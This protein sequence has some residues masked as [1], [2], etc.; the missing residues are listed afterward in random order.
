MYT[1]LLENLSS[2]YDGN[3][4][5]NHLKSTQFSELVFDINP[6]ALVTNYTTGSILTF[7]ERERYF[8]TI[9]TSYTNA[10]TLYFDYIV[11]PNLMSSGFIDLINENALKLNG[12]TLY[13]TGQTIVSPVT[14]IPVQETANTLFIEKDIIIDSVEPVFYVDNF[15]YKKEVIN[16]Q[17]A[18]NP[19]TIVN[20]VTGSQSNIILDQETD[21]PL[22]N[23]HK[24]EF[25][26]NEL[27]ASGKT[28]Y[29]II[30]KDSTILPI[31]GFKFSETES[32]GLNHEGMLVVNLTE[33]NNV[34]KVIAKL[35]EFI[36]TYYNDL[37][38]S[39]N[40]ENPTITI[41]FDGN[42]SQIETSPD[43]IN[44]ISYDESTITPETVTLYNKLEYAKDGD[45]IFIKVTCSKEI[46][47]TK[48]LTVTVNN[49]TAYV[50]EDQKTRNSFYASYTIKSS[51][52]GNLLEVS[53]LGSDLAGNTGS[54]QS[55]ENAIT[56]LT[57]ITTP[58]P[59]PSKPIYVDDNIPN[60]MCF[61]YT[62]DPNAAYYE[63]IFYKDG[64]L[65]E[66]F[67]TPMRSYNTGFISSSYY[68]EGTYTCK[69]RAV[70]NV[71]LI[72]D[73][74]PISDGH[75]FEIEK[76]ECS[77]EL[78]EQTN[79]QF[80][81]LITGATSSDVID[82][83]IKYKKP[84]SLDIE[85]VTDI[86]LDKIYTENLAVGTP[87]IL[88]NNSIHI[89]LITIADG[90]GVLK[91]DEGFAISYENNEKTSASNTIELKIDK[92][93]PIININTPLNV[94]SLKHIPIE[95]V[96]DEPISKP[97]I[98]NF[99]IEDGS[100]GTTVE[101]ISDGDIKFNVILKVSE[102][103]S[104]CEIKVKLKAGS[105]QDSAGNTNDVS[106]EVIIIHNSILPEITAVNSK[107][108][109]FNINDSIYVDVTFSQRAVKV[110]QTKPFIVG[111]VNTGTETAPIIFN[112]FSGSGTTNLRFRHVVSSNDLDGNV[113]LLTL[114]PGS[115]IIDILN[116]VVNTNISSFTIQGVFIVKSS[117]V[118]EYS[119]IG[120][121]K[122][123]AE[124]LY[125][126]NSI[127][128]NVCVSGI[129]DKDDLLL[130]IFV[131]GSENYMVE[132]EPGWFYLKDKEYYLYSD[133]YKKE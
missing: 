45:L 3:I 75:T 50:Q 39:Y 38:I 127:L 90:N 101:S 70:N 56:S 97:T 87:T 84:G 119:G 118:E 122:D 65:I 74:S 62:V 14:K 92:E 131:T 15:V 54:I 34:S 85:K 47:Y 96:S 114:N 111:Q 73:Y 8:A 79:P 63:Y 91:I 22:I 78:Y 21:T 58:L 124:S 9:R 48:P 130:N 132:L 60:T 112:Y 76:L 93:K 128:N 99:E 40:I 26:I 20:P 81:T 29:I 25:V 55:S 28:L 107:Q 129:G 59:A 27:P 116:N 5:V 49:N 23:F 102:S 80:T 6:E 82:L 115:G 44:I 88:P 41:F 11:Q 123:I 83:I 1:E 98:S 24:I 100:N 121:S 52:V 64:V 16:L 18:V 86:S 117:N 57:V 42:I 104:S 46:D 43:I 13:N 67:K 125:G 53:V 72:S 32:S 35:Q 19:V 71:G 31:K 61:S 94:T 110:T 113:E 30:T 105:V 103:V 4:V 69:I 37:Y 10:S 108:G 68:G 36:E 126:D 133:K 109:Y 51:D 33:N 12:G 106:N 120:I 17:P 2:L 66:D 77:L 95:V 7:I 89:P